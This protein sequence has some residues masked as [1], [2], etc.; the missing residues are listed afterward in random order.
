MSLLMQLHLTAS[1]HDARS[2]VRQWVDSLDGEW[3]A[4]RDR[5]TA[6]LDRRDAIDDAIVW[7]V[8]KIAGPTLLRP[9]DTGHVDEY[10]LVDARA[11]IVLGELGALACA[12]GLTQRDAQAWAESST[13]SPAAWLLHREGLSGTTDS[14]CV[15][16][17]ALA[18]SESP[19]R[20]SA[21]TAHRT[22]GGVEGS[23]LDRL[24]ELRMSDLCSSVVG[25]LEAASRRQVRELWDGPDELA[26]PAEWEERLPG[27]CS[28]L[29]SF[30]GLHAEGAELRHCVGTDRSYAEGIVNGQHEM[31]SIS[32][33]SDRGTAQV[34]RGRVVQCR[35]PLNAE[36]SG[37]VSKLA[38]VCAEIAGGAR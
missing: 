24:D 20:R 4:V 2:A 16:R 27:G 19:A 22:I 29:R 17:W 3:G 34:A 37:T 30:N 9:T 26:K 5:E 35:G 31:I 25:T 28:R 8:L 18:M 13:P 1:V 23:A 38:A 6:P 11:S 36:P 7:R 32:A 21:L 12:V 33:G 15:A 10:A 14:V